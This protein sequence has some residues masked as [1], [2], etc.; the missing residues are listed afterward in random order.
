MKKFQSET[1]ICQAS[2]GHNIFTG[3]V[4]YFEYQ[5]PHQYLCRGTGADRM[6]RCYQGL[7]KSIK[8][9]I[10]YFNFGIFILCRGLIINGIY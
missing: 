5:K 8:D 7:F 10:F 1:Q 2:F 6:E 9:I 3:M 4:L